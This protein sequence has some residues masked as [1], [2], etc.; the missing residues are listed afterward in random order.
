M[1]KSLI[2]AENLI[3]MKRK[4]FLCHSVLAALLFLPLLSLHAEVS[5]GGIN[6]YSPKEAFFTAD[7]DLP[8]ENRI[9]S[10]NTVFQ[11][12]LDTKIMQ[13]LTFFPENVLYLSEKGII[14]I[15]NRFGVFRSD[16]TL[17]RFQPV[18]EFPAFVN[19]SQ[20]Q[21]GKISG[22]DASPDGGWL[23]YMV[24]TSP[25]YGNLVLLDLIKNR[26]TI[27][28][29]NVEYCYGKPKV[30][31]SGDSKILI[32]EKSGTL[33]YHTVDPSSPGSSVAENFRKTGSG[34]INNAVWS[35]NNLFLLKDSFVFKIRSSEI[36]TTSLYSEY[37][38][39]GEALGKI[40]FIYDPNFDNY[41]ISPG[42]SEIIISKG[43]RNL[44]YYRLDKDVFFSLKDVKS[45]PH[46]FLPRNTLIKELVWGEDGIVT[47]LTSTIIKGKKETAIFRLL[48]DSAGGEPDFIRLDETGVFG[49]ALSAD[50]SKIALIRE[51]GVSIKW[52]QS[53][54]TFRE[55]DF[56]TPMHVIWLN[57]E[58]IAIFGKN[59]SEMRKTRTGE[60]DLIT[61][62]QAEALGYQAP[63]RSIICRTDG[64]YFRWDGSGGWSGT[65]PV[66]FSGAVNDSDLYRLYL[67]NYPGGSYKNIVYLRD[68][69]GYKTEA[70]FPLPSIN[71]DPIPKTEEPVDPKNFKH[72]S[73]TRGRYISLVFNAVKDDS[74]LTE[75]L[76]V[77]SDYGIKATFFVSG[78]FIKRH[79]GAVSEIAD[80]G[81]ETGSLFYYYFDL[82]DSRYGIDS[83]FIVK[84]LARN[85]DEYFRTT[86]RELSLFWHAPNYFVNSMMIEAAGKM[87]YTYIGR[88]IISLDSKSDRDTSYGTGQFYKPASQLLESISADKKPGSIIPITI[89]KPE[90]GRADYLF[91]C[92]EVLINDLIASG[93]EIVPVTAQINLAK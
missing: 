86:G 57:N 18:L 75:I 59:V 1:N 63:S 72:G 71:Y 64:N 52:H 10:Y 93:Y 88:D 70:L 62:S 42:G 35:G 28:S 92:I 90:N 51:S 74:G 76:N 32:Y 83:D 58:D 34:R 48:T 12:E 13:Q 43:G 40:P 79:P 15:S 65:S 30:K 3:S 78:D 21:T 54:V 39:T 87:N 20:V 89:G 46:I 77:L 60:K 38:D 5:F 29:S 33:Y 55:Y 31:W 66:T 2:F 44:F 47:V 67:E 16:T 9:S 27:I 8:G 23:V 49:M 17:K 26:E 56:N 68:I 41:W 61:V 4:N 37:I 19:G 69:K 22:T 73:R 84:G 53:W 14:Q 85:E 24:K 81:H 50:G 11:A 36:F 7:V 6:L 82:T 80:S 45:L 25:G 91:Q